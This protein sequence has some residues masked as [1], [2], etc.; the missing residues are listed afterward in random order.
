MDFGQLLVGKTDTI[1]ENW[2]E[3][4][5]QDRQIE[6]A[7]NLSRRAIEDHLSQVLAA[8][9]T[10]LS[11]SQQSEI[12]PVVKASLYHGVL[13]AEQGFEP[14]EIA[15]EYRILRQVVFSTLEGELLKGKPAE[16]L[17]AVRLIDTTVDEAI[18]QCFKS[19]VDE[20]LRELE[21]LQSQLKLTNQELTRLVRTGQD[22]LTHLAHELKN[23]LTSI[24]GYSDMFLRSSRQHPEVKDTFA[25]LEHIERVLR[26]GR[27]LLRLINDSLE[28][29]RCEAG[30][31]KLQPTPTHVQSLIDNVMEM[32]EPLARMKELQMVVDCDRAPETVLTDSLRLQQIV[33]NIVSNAIRYTETG[34]VEV[35]CQVLADDKWEISVSDTGRGIAPE[36][37]ARIFEPF[38]R[39][40]SNTQPRLPDS[41]GLG[42]AIVSRLV[43]LLQ[44]EIKLT[45]QVGVSSTFTVIFPL[46][47]KTTASNG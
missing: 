18:S 8:M 3:A 19:Y 11:Q 2:V 1:I 47:I 27:H 4:V 23:P 25:N 44:G 38:F 45:S 7:D 24:I 29:S 6:S 9:A 13:R 14:T 17:R 15:R 39:V 10:V 28:V 37:Q 32:L 31:M 40:N 22:N 35:N 42:L 20:R 30:E 26:N 5:R 16:L 21:H 34:T 46:E 33:T 41:T 12:Q 36:D 43:K